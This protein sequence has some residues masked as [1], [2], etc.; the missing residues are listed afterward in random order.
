MIVIEYNAESD[1]DMFSFIGGENNDT[2]VCPVSVSVSV[3][4]MVEKKAVVSTGFNIDND[5]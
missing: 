2:S 4:A 1:V 3:C 5:L